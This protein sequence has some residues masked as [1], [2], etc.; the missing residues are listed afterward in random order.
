MTED[1]IDTPIVMPEKKGGRISAIETRMGTVEEAIGILSRAIQAI[2]ADVKQ[3][4][5]N[6]RGVPLTPSEPIP[7]A[8]AQISPAASEAL[9]MMKAFLSMQ[10]EMKAGLLNDIKI[11]QT[12]VLNGGV[13]DEDDGDD[14][15]PFTDAL[16]PVLKQFIQSRNSGSV[17]SPPPAPSLSPATNALLAPGKPV[18]L[19]KPMED[20]E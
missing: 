13:D 2:H 8:P 14:G 10:N 3:L 17:G 18:D 9:S 12:L 15:D 7:V 1:M 6:Q 19:T 20:D 16:A 11:A 5:P 4:S